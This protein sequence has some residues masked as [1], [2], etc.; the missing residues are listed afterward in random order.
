LGGRAVLQ[1]LMVIDEDDAGAA[2]SVYILGANN[3]MG[4]ENAAPSIT[5]ANARA[6]QAIIDIATGDYKDLGGVK[7][8][9]IRNIGALLEADAASRDLYVAIV[10]STGTPTYSASGLKLVFGFLQD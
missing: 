7:V 4:T 5:D 8:A 2:F 3:S 9:N 1:S 6:I 10:N